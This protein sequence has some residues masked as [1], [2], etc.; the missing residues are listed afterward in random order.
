MM[1]IINSMEIDA[2]P[3]KVFYWLEEPERAMQWQSSV[4]RSE[5]IKETPN[6]VNTT[7]REYIEED[8]RGIEM[9]GIITEFVSNKRF[10]AHLESKLNSVDV[11]FV[12]EGKNGKTQ[13]TQQVEFRFK[14]ILKIFGLFLRGSIK[15][16]I[17]GQ[18][19]GELS[20]LK[21]LC[22]QVDH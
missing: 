20:K 2:A 13:M 8:G 4:T 15:K 12:L 10:A 6:R 9:Q 18:A 21:T 19:L 22:E 11:S 14:G 16:K 17:K 3:D 5:T 7:Y 1:K